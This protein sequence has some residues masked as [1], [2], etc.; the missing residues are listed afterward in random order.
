[1]TAVELHG[2][3]DAE[4]DALVIEKIYS[5][6]KQ[7]CGWSAVKHRA[8]AVFA[9]MKLEESGKSAEDRERIR[10]SFV[11]N[12]YKQVTRQDY[13]GG[14][15]LDDLWDLILFVSSRDIVIAMLLVADSMGDQ[16]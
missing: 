15:G 4:L 2:K 9:V 3:T 5:G 6:R 14:A 11:R 12:V 1:M 13:D 16:A 7:C 10:D 8:T